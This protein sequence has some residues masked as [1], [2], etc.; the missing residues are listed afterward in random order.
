MLL[1]AKVRPSERAPK[2][3]TVEFYQ[4]S[5]NTLVQR[6][7]WFGYFVMVLINSPTLLLEALTHNI[8]V[9]SW[10]SLL[11]SHLTKGYL[12]LKMFS[13]FTKAALTSNFL[14]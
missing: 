1:N 3:M 11:F 8:R 5:A 13:H 10:V 7:Y 9:L 12:S 2:N 6:K 4:C 14:N